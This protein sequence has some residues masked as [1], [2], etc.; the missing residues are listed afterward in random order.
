MMKYFAGFISILFFIF[1]SFIEY[2]YISLFIYCDFSLFKSGIA[3]RLKIKIMIFKL[4]IVSISFIL[5][6][7]TFM[8]IFDD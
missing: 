4:K 5:K 1:E 2:T 8:L 3:S 7:C 6:V